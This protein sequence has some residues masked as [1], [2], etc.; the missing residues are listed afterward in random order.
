MGEVKSPGPQPMRGDMTIMQALSMAGGFLDFAKTGD[1]RVLR[2]GA[3]G[4]ETLKFNYKKA[5]KGEVDP[6]VLRPGDIVVV[7]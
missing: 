5:V 4:T 3:A 6:L 1:I 7:P 2:K